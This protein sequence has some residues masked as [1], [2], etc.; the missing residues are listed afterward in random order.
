MKLMTIK[1]FRGLF[2]TFL[3]FLS[4][5]I[6]G[7]CQKDDTIEDEVAIH[8]HTN[9]VSIDE[10]KDR[11][12]DKAYLSNLF[13]DLKDFQ[14]KFKTKITDPL[15]GASLLTDRIVAIERDGKIHYNFGIYAPNAQ[16]KFY[17]FVLTT[18]MG[19]LPISELGC[20]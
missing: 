7:S 8:R 14:T 4:I 15:Q 11:I 12:S 20:N 1:A 3:V 13:D 2:K 9:R 18:L 5:F 17:N 10:L 16:G 6:L 19:E